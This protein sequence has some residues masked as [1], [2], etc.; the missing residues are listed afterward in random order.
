MRKLLLVRHAQSQITPGV[1]PARWPLTDAGRAAAAEFAG[2]LAPHD[3]RLV[4]TSLEPKAAETGK[5][6][7]RQL[8]IP[9]QEASGLH[10]QAR[11]AF[12]RPLTEA[13][14]NALVKRVL[15]EPDWTGFGLETGRAALSRFEAALFAVLKESPAG[16]LAVV[17]H[18]TVMALFVSKYNPIDVGEFWGRLRMPALAVL[19]LPGF[20]LLP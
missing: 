3:P 6:I 4:V 15:A 14:F 2:E 18:G 8:G 10:E 13:A 5:L 20:E 7:A 9:L 19:R 17:T 1:E 12:D 11:A 16:S